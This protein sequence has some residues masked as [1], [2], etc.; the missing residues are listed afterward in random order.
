MV[1]LMMFS[2]AVSVKAQENW[3]Q[4]VEGFREGQR[5]NIFHQDVARGCPDSVDMDNDGDLDLLIGGDHYIRYYRND[6]TRTSPSWTLVNGNLLNMPRDH[7]YHMLDP[8]AADMDNDGDQDLVISSWPG[9][10]Y[11]YRNDGNLTFTQITSS[12]VPNM[13][14]HASVKVRDM[15]NDSDYDIMLATDSGKIYFFR[16]IGTRTNP[17]FAAPVDLG[18]TGVYNYDRHI[19]LCDIDGD[20]DYDLFFSEAH[21]KYEG[22]ESRFCFYRNIGT[23]EN[24]NFVL[25]TDQYLPEVSYR[26]MPFH[27]FFD[28]DADGDQDALLFTYQSGGNGCYGLLK[29]IGTSSEPHWDLTHDYFN[30][31]TFKYL[32]GIGALG[33]IDDDGDLDMVQVGSHIAFGLYENIGSPCSP[34]W[35][36][37]DQFIPHS[38]T[39]LNSPVLYDIDNDGDLDFFAVDWS[40][41][42]PGVIIF[43][44]NIGSKTN[45][46]YVL[47]SSGWKGIAS[48]AIDPSLCIGDINGDGLGD[49]LMGSYPSSGVLLYLNIGT[50]SNPVFSSPITLVNVVPAGSNHVAPFLIDIDRDDDL[51]LFVGVDNHPWEGRINF[52]RNTGNRYSYN[53]VLEDSQW[54]GLTLYSYPIVRGGDI[55]GDGF[56]NIFISDLNGGMIQYRC[57]LPSLTVTPNTITLL[58]GQSVTFDVTGTSGTT[59]LEI[60]EN[61]SGSSIMGMQY[62]SGTTTDVVDKI[63]ASDS[64]SSKIGYSYVNVIS[65]SQLSASGKAVIMAGRRPSDPLWTTTNNLAHFIYRTLLYRGFS[66]DNIYYLNPDPNQDADGNGS[67]DDID[68]A[69][70]HANIEYALTSWANGSPNLFVYLIDHGDELGIDHFIRCNET[71][72]LY[73]SELDPWLDA[74][75]NTGTDNLTL[76][77]DCCLSGGFLSRCTPP[78]G[79]DRIVITSS[80]I[81]E[82]AFFSAGGLISFT[83]AFVQA[84][85]SGLTI[86]DAF[87]LGASA[88]D[89][90]QKPQL[91]D[92]G[93][94]VY[95]KD[96]DGALAK[97]VTLGATFIAGADRPQIGNI[98]PNQTLTGGTS[99][100]AIWASDV[101]SV[102]PI[103]RV[104]AT[105]AS[106]SFIPNA[107][108][109]PGEP[110]TGLPELTL[111][112]NDVSK[113]YEGTATGLTEMGAYAINIYAKD[114]WGGVS[115]PKQM[116]INQSFSDEKIII[117]CGDGDY[118]PDAPWASSD[119]LADMVYE[120]AIARWITDLRIIY[121][122][123]SPDSRVDNA[124]T[125]TN[126]QNAISSAAGI[127]KLTVYLVGSGNSSAFDINGNGPDSGDVTPSEL[128]SWLDSLQGS[129]STKVIVVLDFNQSGAWVSSLVAPTGK[130]RIVITSCNAGETSWC[131]AGGVLSFT[132]WF[133]NK[134][135]NGVNVRDCFNWAMNA[136][137]TMTYNVQNPQLD[138]NNS[139]SFNQLD[140]NLAKVTYIGAAFVTGLDAPQIGDYAGYVLLPTSTA[141]LWASGVWAPEGIQ[142]IFALI[143]KPDS[144]AV[145]VALSYN[146]SLGRYE[147]TYNEF[148]PHT[149]HSVIYFAKDRQDVLSEPYA[150]L[151]GVPGPS[152]A[153]MWELYE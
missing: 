122:S 143:V 108:T 69:S 55:D 89:R 30:T 37:N 47:E 44:R 72:V 56:S 146:S 35:Y 34:N 106:P 126:L 116:Y 109:N 129:G 135:F 49:L 88:M 61:R 21:V 24:Y 5:L 63:K 62:T 28:P 101:S 93:D 12:F 120:T 67:N 139:G 64:G 99:Q 124:P 39:W 92:N 107:Q 103:D 119:Y 48:G 105:I 85:Y 29:N 50:P 131:K 150:T 144:S 6:G 112:W 4:V 14:G 36:L 19:S 66:K 98:T 137:R 151:F 23:P 68:A 80:N 27:T 31:F 104:W 52:F 115:Y 111:V 51:D 8:A 153:T 75:Q 1:I 130:Q 149:Q 9:A 17:S 125:K 152:A 90:Y 128:D 91:D 60:E 25:V 148:I 77:V 110:V 40:K 76:V 84:L 96:Q 59:T 73:A 38:M 70:T 94:G 3:E 145:K 32:H 46:H 71:E 121:L 42:F 123:S 81:T 102:Y 118:A 97:T 10:V 79:K 58:S 132:Q 136:V 113:K 147:A 7:T 53:Y 87:D 83:S 45:P 95:D 127:S 141:T 33:D 13:G 2:N 15:D 11:Y 138:D 142:E 16:N 74:L 134:V 57:K 65:V 78:S 140:G 41:S 18:I 43:W 54:M 133:F 100:A 86:G 20:Q 22:T 82:P 26:C 117:V 114:I